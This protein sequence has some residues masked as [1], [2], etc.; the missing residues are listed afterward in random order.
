MFS[1]EFWEFF[2]NTFSTEHVRTTASG[3]NVLAKIWN[4]Y[5]YNLRR[6]V[7][8]CNLNYS[9]I[10]VKGK[11][12]SS[13]KQ[14]LIDLLQSLFKGK[15]LRWSLFLNKNVGLQSWNFIKK[16]LLQHR[17]FPLNIA[18]FLRTPV[19]ENICERLFERFPTWASNIT[20]NME[21][22]QD[23]FSKTKKKLDS[24][25]G[26]AVLSRSSRSKMFCE[27]VF[28]EILQNS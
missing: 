8:L 10:S 7:F 23:I 21:I 18:K 20:R 22:E 9:Q 11:W 17:F 15:H 27:K 2:K 14:V 16:R 24:Q 3:W 4:Q 25:L 5:S 28:F 26:S 13:E 19:L 1:Y 12:F 6:I